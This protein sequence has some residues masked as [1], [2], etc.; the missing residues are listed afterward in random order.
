MLVVDIE[1]LPGSRK[2]RYAWFAG[3]VDRR[4]CRGKVVERG[5]I[6][7]RERVKSI[8]L[9]TINVRGIRWVMKRSVLLGYVELWIVGAV[10][11]AIPEAP[12]VHS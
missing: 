11:L 3:E 12:S 2:L 9:W 5:W 10:T 4:T 6:S 8:A 7:A 1:R